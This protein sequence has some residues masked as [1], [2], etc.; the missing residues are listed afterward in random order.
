MLGMEII[1]EAASISRKR[2]RSWSGTD[3]DVVVFIDSDCEADPGWLSA[4]CNSYA[5]ASNAPGVVGLT[6]HRAETSVGYRAAKY[7]GLLIGFEF[8]NLM[9]TA[10]WGPCSNLSLRRSAL[11]AAGGFDEVH[12]FNASE[13]VDLGLRVTAT[14]GQMLVCSRDAVVWHAPVHFT[15]T[16]VRRAWG[17]GYGEAALLIQHPERHIVAPPGGL[18]FLLTALSLSGLGAALGSWGFMIALILLYFFLSPLAEAI[19]NHQSLHI[20]WLAHILR[21]L[22]ILHCRLGLLRRGRIDLLFTRLHYGE[23]QLIYEWEAA[24]RPQWVFL[25]FLFAGLLLNWKW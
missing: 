1:Y 3:A 21:G 4:H 18:A 5:A 9:T 2:N 12:F 23:E 17:W 25:V 13:D 24:M 8:P 20:V 15:Q 10:Y 19:Q 16:L 6:R 14:S 22:F 11:Q 7:A